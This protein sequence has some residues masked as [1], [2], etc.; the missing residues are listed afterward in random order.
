M[1]RKRDEKYNPEMLNNSQ[2]VQYWFKKLAE[3][4]L[5]NRH[6]PLQTKFFEERFK[7]FRKFSY[8]HKVEGKKVEL[9]TRDIAKLNEI[10]DKYEMNDGFKEMMRKKLN[11]IDALSQ[12]CQPLSIEHIERIRKLLNQ[13]DYTSSV[14]IRVRLEKALAKLKQSL[15]KQQKI[16]DY[17][18]KIEYTTVAPG[19]LYRN[20]L[21]ENKRLNNS[22]CPAINK[23]LNKIEK[24]FLKD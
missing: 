7:R 12:T 19:E 11:E 13:F 14:I 16:E 20:E 17:L 15:A 18:R 21:I 5:I 10:Y 2:K 6:S 23:Y 24:T 8:I 4:R 9:M 3:K 22:F 1:Y